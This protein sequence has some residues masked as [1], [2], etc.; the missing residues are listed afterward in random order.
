VIINRALQSNVHPIHSQKFVN[1]NNS[2]YSG[3]QLICDD[4]LTDEMSQQDIFEEEREEK[5]F[6]PV[7]LRKVKGQI[8]Y[9]SGKI[10]GLVKPK[11]KEF[12][13]KIGL[14]WSIKL[15]ELDLLIL[16]KKP[17]IKKVIFAAENAIPII[18][19]KDFMEKLEY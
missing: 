16:G 5:Q 13:E 9:V 2:L 15:E 12:I 1:G 10:E 18:R 7:Y 14:I 4:N 8:C 17:G 11:V 6:N 3:S 19:W